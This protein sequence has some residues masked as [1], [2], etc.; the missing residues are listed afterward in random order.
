MK[1]VTSLG[2]HQD[3]VRITGVGMLGVGRNR[4]EAEELEIAVARIYVQHL[5]CCQ[6]GDLCLEAF[7]LHH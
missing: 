4:T 2:Y 7:H 1:T 5:K 6:T 3:E